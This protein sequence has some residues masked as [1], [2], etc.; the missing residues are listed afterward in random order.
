ML[1]IL[2]YVSQ[3]LLSIIVFDQTH[4]AMSIKYICFLFCHDSAVLAQCR[5]NFTYGWDWSN[6]KD[7]VARCK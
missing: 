4:L 7:S 6:F 1:I 5:F 2:K 3:I